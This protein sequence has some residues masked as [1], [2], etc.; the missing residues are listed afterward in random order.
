MD[1]IVWTGTES[2]NFEIVGD[3]DF[4][5]IEDDTQSGKKRVVCDGAT[6]LTHYYYADTDFRVSFWLYYESGQT[7]FEM[8]NGED[9]LKIE[10]D[11]T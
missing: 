11:G 1:F 7:V 9:T 3:G 6:I 8:T 10:N 4:S 5:L 2:N